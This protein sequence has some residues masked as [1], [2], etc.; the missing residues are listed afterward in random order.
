MATVDFLRQ[1]LLGDGHEILDHATVK[2]AFYAAVRTKSTGEIW[3]LVVLTRSDKDPYYNFCYKDM[4]E[5]VGPYECECPARIIKML[6]PTDSQWANE[7]RQKCLDN[8]SRQN[9]KPKVDNGQWIKFDQPIHFTNGQE[10][11]TFQLRKDGRK[12]FFAS[13]T[14]GLYRISNWKD[15]EFQLMPV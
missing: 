8:A 6:T 10:L 14:G 4:D 7:W 12:T 13:V 3:G 5:T 15:R 11:D 9:N 2:R 1:E